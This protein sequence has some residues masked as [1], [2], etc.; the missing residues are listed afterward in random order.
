MVVQLNKVP[1][2]MFYNVTMVRDIRQASFINRKSLKRGD[3]DMLLVSPLGYKHVIYRDE[4]MK[5]Y[6]TPDGK[7]IRIGHWRY[8]KRYLVMSTE[9]I[10]MGALKIPSKSRVKIVLPNNREIQ[11]G[12]YVLCPIG[13]NG[14]IIKQRPFISN[15]SVF[16]KMFR[17]D[18]KPTI[19]STAIRMANRGAVGKK[20]NGNIDKDVSVVKCEVVQRILNNSTGKIIG[21]VVSDGKVAKKLSVSQVMTM[22]RLKQISNITIVEKDSKEFLRGVGIRIENLPAIIM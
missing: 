7:R 2:D 15:K 11:N 16:N 19:N 12:I 13:Q 9:N 5:K 6:M 18:K 21:F 3:P 14:S 17:V 1:D 10:A 22:C 20:R 8:G 4:L